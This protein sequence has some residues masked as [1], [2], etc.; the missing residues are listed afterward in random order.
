MRYTF[1]IGKTVSVF[2]SVRDMLISRLSL[3]FRAVSLII[4]VMF[5][6]AFVY[7]HQKVGIYVGA[8]QLNDSYNYYEELTAKRDY[9]RYAFNKEA[10]LPKINQ[11]VDKNNFSFDTREK[12]LALNL[13]SK[14]QKR[15]AVSR[16]AAVFNRVI[17]VPAGVGTAMAHND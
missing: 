1:V 13:K 12:V 4:S 10:T 14:T 9:L 7:L 6:C 5:V 3:S 15:S 17:S 2:S 11:W 8:Y 16:A